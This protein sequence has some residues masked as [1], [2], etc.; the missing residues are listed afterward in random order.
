MLLFKGLGLQNADIDGLTWIF[1][2]DFHVRL[3]DGK[4][5]RLSPMDSPFCMIG[6]VAE[7]FPSLNIEGMSQ[8]KVSMLSSVFCCSKRLLAV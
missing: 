5:Q 1:G 8:G 4:G 6:K 7:S 3:K 2:S